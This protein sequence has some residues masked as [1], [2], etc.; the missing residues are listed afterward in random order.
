LGDR[1]TVLEP[2]GAG[3]MGS[4]F[5]GADASTGRPVAIKIL[6][7]A[8]LDDAVLRE[9]F[10]REAIALAALHHPGIVSVVD[11]GEAGGDLWM[12]LELLDG[13]TL[14]AILAR[15]GALAWG[16]AH[17]LFDQVLDALAACHDAGIVHRDVKPSNVMVSDDGVRLIDFGLARIAR[18]PIEKLTETGAVQGTPRY[19]APEQCRGEEVGPPA[20]VYSTAI[21]IYEALAGKEP[22]HGADAATFMAQHLF[23]DPADLSEVAPHVPRGVSAAVHAALAKHPHDRPTARELREALAAARAGRD[24]SSV[25]EA[26]AR[27]RRDGSLLDRNARA[28]GG[29]GGRPSPAVASGTVV[30]AMRAG[31]R[32]S[33]IMSALGAAGFACT[34]ATDLDGVPGGASV[35][36]VSASDGLDRVARLRE[37]GVAVVV[38]D[39]DSPRATTA[40]IRAGAADM[41]LREAAD[42]DLAPKVLRLLRKRGRA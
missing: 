31:D 28:L 8:L 10:R 42:A 4:I 20:D 3:A 29:G 15:E 25:A 2:L 16:R 9:R 14:E 22:F 34:L 1:F 24:P 17:P 11:F 36:V 12:A 27:T 30:V 38:V 21:V 6:K 32:S 33:S 41:L 19:M 7:R 5:R 35:A 26:A 40:A 18:G 13:E 37:R 39:V 23:V